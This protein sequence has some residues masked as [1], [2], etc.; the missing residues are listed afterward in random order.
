MSLYPVTHCSQQ[1]T[2]FKSHPTK[3]G[4]YMLY[5]FNINNPSN[6]AQH[7]SGQL[8]TE[9]GIFTLDSFKTES[10]GDTQ[11]RVACGKISI[12]APSKDELETALRHLNWSVKQAIKIGIPAYGQAAQSSGSKRKAQ[13]SVTQ[14][15]VAVPAEED[16][17]LR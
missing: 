11:K 17:D 4:S 2:G 12:Q 7:Y 1:Q 10:D 9:S 16:E 15:E 6:R 5:N 3:E 14:A 8:D 13:A